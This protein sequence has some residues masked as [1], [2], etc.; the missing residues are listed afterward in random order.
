MNYFFTEDQ[1]M[2]RDLAR[3]IADEKIRPVAAE[4]DENEEF[5]TEIMKVMAS[6]DLFALP[7]PQDYGGLGMGTTELCLVVEEIS[8]A[9]AAVA[10]TYAASFLGALPII[11]FGSEEQKAKYFPRIAQAELTAFGLTE[12]DAGSDAGGIRTTAV[13]DGDQ[14]VL[15]GTKQWITNGGEAGIY[16]IIALTDKS[17]GARGASAFIVEKGTPGFSFGKK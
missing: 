10:V 14:Y 5:P 12:A 6:S 9:C 8:K 7:V 15:N 17:K 1:L 16:T 3:Q 4:M 2:L 11:L 13:R